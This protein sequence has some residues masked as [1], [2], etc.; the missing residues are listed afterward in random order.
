MFRLVNR[1]LLLLIAAI[2]LLGIMSVRAQD[3][4]E[5]VDECVAETASEAPAEAVAP[6]DNSD[7]S[8]TIILPNPRGDRSFIDSAAAGAERAIAE[9]GVQGTIV[10]T[11]GVQEHDAAIRRAV[12][13]SPDLIITIAVDASTIE[14]IAD[15]FPDQLF[16]AQETFFPENP[17]YDNLALFNIFTHENSY[18]AGVAAGML[19]R[20]KIVGAVGGGDFPG[21]N[22]FIIGFEEGVKSVCPECQT[23]RSYVGSFSDPVTAKEQALNLY[24]EGADILYQV[25]GRSGEGVL[26]AASETGNLAIGVDSNQDDLYPGSIMVSAMKRVDNAVFGFVESIVNDTYTP[27]VTNVGMAEGYAGLSWDLGICSRTFDENGPEDLVAKLPEV[28]QAIAEA[29]A[30][31]LAGDIVVTNALLEPAS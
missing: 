27:G 5:Y 4:T 14:E 17:D 30:A 11:A 13:D 3:T 9:L 6:P 18:L 15:E 10:E 31:I 20:T 2:T 22:L 1:R 7:I 29:R 25:A 8:F 19:T 26:A 24:T 28:R 16:A 21:I 12:Q 23:L